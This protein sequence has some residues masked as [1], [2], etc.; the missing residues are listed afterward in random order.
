MSLPKMWRPALAGFVLALAACAS[1]QAGPQRVAATNPGESGSA[2]SQS[3]PPAAATEAFS[4]DLAT[5]EDR[6]DA[7]DHVWH[8]VNDRFYDPS[9]N[10]V[11]WET[12]RL[13]YFPQLDW[14]RSDA[15]FYSLLGRMV[16]EL[17]DSHTRVYGARDYRNRIESVM[18]TVGVRIAEVEG[19]VAVVEV[20]SA[21]PA[22]A[23]GM[24]PGMIVATINGAAA[25]AR[26]RRIDGEMSKD[27]SPERRQRN[28]FGRMLGSRPGAPL[29]MEV[30]RDGDAGLQR[31]ELPRTEL[32]VPV[33]VSSR[34]VEGNV[35]VIA[36]NRFRP[37]A[38]ADVGRALALLSETD[39]L[40][41]DLRGNP[42]GNIG[43]ML[44]IAQSFFPEARHV[45]TRRTRASGGP[46]PEG[47]ASSQ[48]TGPEV[49]ITANSR[50]YTR[51]LAI[52]IDGYSA[53]SSE[54]LATVL[55][56][57]RDALIVGRP[58][59]GCVVGVRGSG[60]RLAGGGALYLAETGFVTPRGNRMEGTGI[61][62]DREVA[63]TLADLRNRVDRD[64]LVARE[65]IVRQSHRAA[66]EH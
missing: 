62:P 19:E 6:E 13:R 54:M 63:L 36:F 50:A 31:F 65:W 14:V 57:Q 60:Y 29:V 53:S 15:A 38:A 25:A 21:T 8:I 56:E 7:F 66:E 3:G 27:A 26:L 52:L 61:H 32:D 18:S 28:I 11:D 9:F 59:C 51:P 48:R 23:A 1:Q 30:R 20:F 49:K 35:G 43:A 39:G 41:I 24:R 2:V 17:R 37:D 16:G 4:P 12:V 42:G 10:G 40:I 45:L 58:S 33:A 44:S 5:V 46:G 47:E 22:A 64:L 55:R 34:V